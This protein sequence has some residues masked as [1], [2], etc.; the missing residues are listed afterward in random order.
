ME[1]PVTF[2]S[3]AARF[4]TLGL[5]LFLLVTTIVGLGL[6]EG[7]PD[8]A[9]VEVAWI[10]ASFAL[11]TLG[12]LLFVA[13]APRLP[14]LAEALFPVRGHWLCRLLG[15]CLVLLTVC[16]V[17]PHGMERAEAMRVWWPSAWIF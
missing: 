14:P 3:E 5:R 2:W 12:S 6:V 4:N 9:T 8:A 1:Q 13:K 15:G 7:S 16:W 10:G 17:I 11:A